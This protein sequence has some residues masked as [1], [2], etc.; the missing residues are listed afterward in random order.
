[1]KPF[2]HLS[3]VMFLLGP[4]SPATPAA[5]H[6][7]APPA[8]VLRGAGERQ[9][10][11]VLSYFWTTPDEDLCVDTEGGNSFRFPRRILASPGA[12][13]RVILWKPAAPVEVRLEAWSDT[14]RDGSPRGKS[15]PIEA[16][17][18]PKTRDGRTIAWKATFPTQPT[19]RHYYL[20]LEARWQ[21]EEGCG[22]SPDLGYQHGAWTFH[23]R[24]R[25]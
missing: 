5:A 13:G 17:L 21:D 4:G 20:R 14:K 11:R 19:P 15:I 3:L 22:G 6:D 9:H 25:N 16:I 7:H 18:A 2:I 1:M 23:L 8:A 12:T 10:G 24:T